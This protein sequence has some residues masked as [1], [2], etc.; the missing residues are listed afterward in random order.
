MFKMHKPKKATVPLDETVGSLFALVIMLVVLLVFFVWQSLSKTELKE[1]VI[2][3]LEELDIGNNLNNF[4]SL[5]LDGGKI[6]SLIA[7]S[8]KNNDYEKLR[9]AADTY[10]SQIYNQKGY[11]Y[12]LV[13]NGKRLNNVDFS[14]KTFKTKSYLP[15]DKKTIEV[16]LIIGESTYI[17]GFI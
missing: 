11:F 5:E 4:L 17:S 13:I 3:T 8:Y 15:A 9:R 10:F 12:D 2:I 6:S 1:K 16:E 14:G 7:E